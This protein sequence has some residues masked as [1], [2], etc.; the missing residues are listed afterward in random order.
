VQ[1]VLAATDSYGHTVVMGVA[2]ALLLIA[3]VRLALMFK[4]RNVLVFDWPDTHRLLLLFSFILGLYWAAKLGSTSFDTDDEIYSWNMWALQHYYNDEVTVLTAG[5]PYPQLFSILISYCYKLLGSIELQLPVKAM[6]AIFPVALWGAIAVAPKEASVANAIRSFVIM[7]LLFVAI[8]NNFGVGL[9]DPLMASSLVVAIFLFM[10][11]TTNTGHRELLVLSVVCAAVALYSKQPG[12]IWA[13]FSLPAIALIATW[14]RRLPFVVLI[15]AGVLLALGLIWVLG[16]GS[17]FHNNQGVI[18]ASQ[19]GRSFFEQ[20]FFAVKKHGTEQ[21]LVPLLLATGI[22]SVMRVRRHRDILFFFLLP[23]LFAWLL[24]GAY[25]LRLGIHVIALSAL[26]LSASSYCLPAILGGGDMP[27]VEKIINRYALIFVIIVP[28]LVAVAAMNQ[29]TKNLKIYGDQ[30]SP[31]IAGKN[32][33]AKFFGK[34]AEFVFKEMYDRPD[35]LMWIPSSYIYGIFYKHTPM[36][37]ARNNLDAA[38]LL[39]DIKRH[40]PNYLIDAGPWVDPG[41]VTKVLAVLAEHQCPYL[42]ERVVQTG[43][44]VYRLRNNDVFIEQ[45]SGYIQRQSVLI[46]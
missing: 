46:P 20:L 39:E 45:C 10:Q 44:V 16:V 14:E 12:L 33:I 22:F 19:E 13:L 8:G 27:K 1:G 38:A 36:I 25:N 9:A 29:I 41:H 18:A 40:R 3:A 17:G 34:D 6:F 4:Q 35:I 24:Y 21:P 28:L 11:Y 26:L 2:I 30:F 43:Y 7:L 23:A 32:S 5:A 37:R 15:G 42:F 31:Y